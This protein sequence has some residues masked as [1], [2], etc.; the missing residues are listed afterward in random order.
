MERERQDRVQKAID[1]INAI[2]GGQD[3]TVG[4]GQATSF[5]PN[6]TYYNADGTVW[7]APTRVSQMDMTTQYDPKTGR[8]VGKS[9]N[10]F[11]GGGDAGGSYY[12]YMMDPSLGSW[13]G[14]GDSGG[15]W[16]PAPGVRV[17]GSG[18]DASET[19]GIYRDVLVPDTA[20]INKRLAAGDLFTGTQTI[21][22]LN[23]QGL[24]DEQR[25]AVT[26]LNSRDVQRQFADAEKANR[27]GLARSGLIGGSADIDSN[28]ELSR[29]TSEGLIKAAGIG[30]QAAADLQ[31]A[32]ERSRQS[33]ISMAQSGID[34]GTAQ[35]T[36]LA[37][38]DA[39]SKNA[40]AARSGATVGNLFS[41]LANSYLYQ[42]Q[43]A[44]LQSGRQGYGSVWQPGVS[45]GVRQGYSGS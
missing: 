36:A 3:R 38:L 31:V 23:R 33:L 26:D 24:Y 9:A 5:N 44:G 37:Q 17:V 30:D 15:Y 12:D 35:Q 19:R 7:V 18:G 22:G 1:T 39:N 43:L 28:A 2:F 14:G 20:A 42:Q 11:G 13:V 25:K 4:T 27:F 8:T 32:D 34:T 21:K 40:A 45:N 6:Q 29:R 16:Q 41:D 10:V